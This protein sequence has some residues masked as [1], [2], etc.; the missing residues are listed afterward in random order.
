LTGD[1]CCYF[2]EDIKQKEAELAE[3]ELTLLQRELNMMIVQQQSQT[4]PTPRK[5]KGKFRYVPDCSVWAFLI[6]ILL[7]SS[8]NSKKTF[9]PTVW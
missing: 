8:K 2:Q 9:I 3:R 1:L 5:R 7:S 4:I 6:R